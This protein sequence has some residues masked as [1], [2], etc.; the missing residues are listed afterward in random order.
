MKFLKN[1]TFFMLGFCVLVGQAFAMSGDSDS[2]GDFLSVNI[3]NSLGHYCEIV[4]YPNEPKHGLIHH[5]PSPTIMGNEGNMTFVLEQMWFSGPDYTFDIDCH[6]DGAVRVTITREWY[7]R[8]TK[9]PKFK[10][11]ES[12]GRLKLCSKTDSAGT[13]WFGHQPGLLSLSIEVDQ[14]H[15]HQSGLSKYSAP[16]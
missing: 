14:C 10:I 2:A 9:Y 8:E 13:S 11:I 4:T 5:A 3:A 12:K 7:F 1:T 16:V 15:H 6:A